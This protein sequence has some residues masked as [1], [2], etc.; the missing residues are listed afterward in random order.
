MSLRSCFIT[1][2]DAHPIFIN[3]DDSASTYA[4]KILQYRSVAFVTYV[5]ELHAQFA[6]E[7]MAC[8]SL[9]N[10]EILNV[11][12]ATEDPNPV[13]KV[14]EKRRLEEIGQEAIRAR[15]DP[16]IVD[17]MRAVRALEDG[18]ILD[19]DVLE[20]QDIDVDGAEPGTKRRRLE[21]EEGSPQPELQQP[22]PQPL[23]LL[24]A[25]TLEGLKYFA[26]I[27]KR[28]GVAPVTKRP[29]PPPLES[30]LGLAEYGSDEED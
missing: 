25:D 23:G 2:T 26:E 14:A 5:S 11:R 6:K 13:Q 18:D 3:T 4:V 20:V 24:S 8:Q 16:R 15:M 12:W 22:P 28:N 9:D 10:D 21:L 1:Y 7:A 17:A 19:E 29:P 30:G 27:R